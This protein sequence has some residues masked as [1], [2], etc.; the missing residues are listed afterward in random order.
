[1]LKQGVLIAALLS[2]AAP[3]AAQEK[4]PPYWASIASG[5]AMMRTGPGKNYP[6]VWLYKRRDLPVRVVKLY[7]NWRLIE[8]P[9]GTRGWMLVTLLSDRRTAIVKPGEP[10]KV[11]ERADDSSRVS[12]LLEPGVVGRIDKC[13]DG[14]CRIAVDKRVGRIHTSDLWGVSEKEVVE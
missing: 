13:A 6:G 1:M 12:Y 8:D 3:A 4:Q 9:D 11:H 14:W 2:L 10:R 7:P 5:E